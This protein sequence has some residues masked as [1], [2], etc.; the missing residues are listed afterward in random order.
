MIKIDIISGFLGAGKTTFIQKILKTCAVMD[1]KVVL[2]EN[3]FG[4][5]GIDGELI[6]KEGF[7]VYEI[8]KGCICCTMKSDF[9]YI[10]SEIIEKINPDR[11]IF[12]PSGIFIPTEILDI[13]KM[14][15]F[16]KECSL[17][18]MVT[19]VD[20]INF[21]QQNSKYGYFFKRQ[22]SDASNIILSKTQ[23]LNNMEID[24]V[25]KKLKEING[26]AEIFAK[27]W[28]HVVTEDIKLILEREIEEDIN[29]LLDFHHEDLISA[30]APQC[31]ISHEHNQE[32]QSFGLKTSKQ[33]DKNTLNNI[34]IKLSEPEYG[35]IIRGKG[36]LKS[37]EFFLEF[38]YVNGQFSIT[39]TD[40][41]T[42]GRIC[43]IGKNIN[44]LKLSNLFNSK[45][46]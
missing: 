13:L 46:T 32:F 43:F 33:F 19:V 21:L 12:E 7:E 17:N 44:K 5:I 18:S 14:P 41:K 42:T 30:T 36:F 11:I 40:F 38:S 34:L 1:E 35:E 2:I 10:L 29:E 27:D 26:Q 22:I 37:Q 23:L 8:S 28:N 4:E 24:E 31:Q 6:R 15:Q 3:E 16:S 20:C 45:C 9:L 25:V 39:K